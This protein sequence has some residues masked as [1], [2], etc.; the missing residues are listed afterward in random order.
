M[1]VNLK[2]LGIEREVEG[3]TIAEALKKFDLSWETIKGKGIMRKKTARIVMNI[4]SI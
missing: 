1:K 2:I 3:E 4:C